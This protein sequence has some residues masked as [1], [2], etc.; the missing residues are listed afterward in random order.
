MNILHTVEFYDP[1][2][3]GMQEVVKQ[4][5]ERL[6]KLGH[7]VTVATTNLP[8][9]KFAKLNGVKIIGFD[10]K[11]KLAMGINGEKQKYINFI[12]NEKFD[13]VTNFAAQQWATDLVL[14]HLDEIKAKKVFV[15]TGFSSL[16]SPLYKNYFK[17][18]KT[19]MKKYDMNVFLSNN[20]R[21]I[22]FA[23]KNKIKKIKIIPNG[24]AKSEFI[25]KSPVDIRKNLKI[26]DYHFLILT[27]GS[28]T[29]IKGHAETIKI[30]RKAKIEKASL[31]II[32]RHSEI[33]DGCRLSCKLSEFFS[34]NKIQVKDLSREETVAAFQAA[35]LFLFASMIECSPIVLFEAMA[36]K[37]PFLTTDV[38]NAKEIIKWTG[39]GKLLPT[40]IDRRGYSHADIG[41]SAEIL[42]QYYNHPSD[43]TLMAG[44]GHKAWLKSFTWEEIAREYE[45]M[46]KQLL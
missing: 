24:A 21:D 33:M 38:G 2:V 41:K 32:G 29:G 31:L 18:M 35:D 26:P 13:I 28:H 19:W 3:G 23:R 9:R 25:K 22:N 7:K 44:N 8:E 27:V 4:L 34:G 1:S 30:F 10:I 14:P 11:G 36:S 45:N 17:K 15:P 12:L 42:K 37:T 5:S 46:Y 16:Y 43:L 40:V 39:G 20:Y 6:V